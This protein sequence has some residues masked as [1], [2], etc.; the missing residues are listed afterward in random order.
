MVKVKILYIFLKLDRNL[1]Y[2][3]KF[4][5]PTNLKA[6]VITVSGKASRKIF[7]SLAWNYG[8]GRLITRLYKWRIKKKP[9]Y[10]Y[11]RDA[12][13]GFAMYL[14]LGKLFLQNEGSLCSFHSQ[15]P[16][17]SISM[18]KQI[19]AVSEKVL[20]QGSLGIETMSCLCIQDCWSQWSIQ[21]Y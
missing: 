5:G 3:I 1:K 12:S 4:P 10:I 14:N 9:G 13:H 6:L 21:Y 16:V 18:M 19:D 8:R 2:C 7:F 15:V 20:C 17:H 11:Q